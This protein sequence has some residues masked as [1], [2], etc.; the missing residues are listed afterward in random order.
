MS[1]H[2]S[3]STWLHHAVLIRFSIYLRLKLDDQAKEGSVRMRLTNASKL[4]HVLSYFNVF[5]MYRHRSSS[6]WKLEKEMNFNF[7]KLFDKSLLFGVPAQPRLKRWLL[8][9]PHSTLKVDSV[10]FPDKSSEMTLHLINPSRSKQS[11][12][13]GLVSKCSLFLF[14]WRL[15]YERCS[16]SSVVRCWTINR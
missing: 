10:D 11:V 3:F 14:A 5:N 2:F 13:F 6:V 1:F 8:A 15:V 12:R 4:R 16:L 9:Q 7:K